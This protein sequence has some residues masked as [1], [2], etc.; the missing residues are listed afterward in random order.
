MASASGTLGEHGCCRSTPFRAVPREGRRSANFPASLRPAGRA[1]EAAGRPR[2]PRSRTS[3]GK[4]PW[5]ARA[6]GRGGRRTRPSAGRRPSRP[7]SARCSGRLRVD[8]AGGALRLRLGGK[9]LLQLPVPAGID[10]DDRNLSGPATAILDLGRV[11]G[12]VLQLAGWSTRS[13]VAAARGIAAWLSR[14]E[15]DA[16]RQP[17]GMPP[18][19]ASMCSL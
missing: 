4:A 1:V 3:S 18:S 6:P 16:G 10:I 12:A 13:P 11:A 8:V 7:R 15:A 14:G 17:A 5:R 19:A 2:E 9:S